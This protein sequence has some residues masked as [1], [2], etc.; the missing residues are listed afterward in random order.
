MRIIKTGI[1][2][3]FVGGGGRTAE[4]EVEEH[5]RNVTTWLK[6]DVPEFHCPYFPAEFGEHGIQPGTELLIY[7]FGGLGPGNDMMERNAKDL[8]EWAEAHPSALVVIVSTF[9]FSNFIEPEMN[10]Q[11]L[12]LPNIVLDNSWQE[13]MC[14]IP[15]W[16]LGHPPGKEEAPARELQK[17]GPPRFNS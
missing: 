7:D 11:G 16:W 8:L 2:V 4:Q 15:E 9:T 6:P 12:T 10:A 17:P 3:D 14:P 13:D 1:I 5:K